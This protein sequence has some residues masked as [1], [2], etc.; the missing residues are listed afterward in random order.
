MPAPLEPA[1]TLALGGRLLVATPRLEDP[2][3]SRAVVLVLE[4]GEPGAV[5]LVLDRPMGVA[6]AEIL[7]P[8]GDLADAAPPGVMFT[9]GPVQPD[10]VVGLASLGPGAEAPAGW[11]AIGPD[12]GVVDLS[13]APAEQLV[14]LGG[15]RLYSGYAGWSTGQLEDEIE[16]GSW[17]VVDAMPGD[18][19][20]ADP[21]RLWHDVLQRQGG[22]LAMLAGYPPT[23]SVN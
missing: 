10:A 2:N 23:P 20:C 5:G 13:V 14:A 21:D 6:V 22:K 1:D 8:W 3:F 19:F 4:H 15:A 18:V 16:E 17:F 9:G 12:A 11:H 7:P